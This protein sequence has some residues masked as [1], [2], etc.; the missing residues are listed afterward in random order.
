MLLLEK[1]KHKNVGTNQVEHFVKKIED[2][3]LKD[4][5]R[6][7]MMGCKIKNAYECEEKMK[8][9]YE[10][11]F[12]YVKRKFG[13]DVGFFNEYRKIMQGEAEYA[14]NVGREKNGK[15]ANFLVSKWKKRPETKVDSEWRNVAISDEKLDEKYE[16]PITKVPNPD[17][18]SLSDN[19]TKVLEIPPGWT[20]H[21]QITVTKINASMESFNC[22]LRW[23]LREREERE[24]EPWTMD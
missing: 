23:A 8:S 2:E 1:L 10:K 11:N 6:R 7:A 13:Q 15:K 16:A 4:H 22:K 18:I 9:K 12:D 19:E 5:M 20:T 3:K 17:N 21:E 24:G 14:W